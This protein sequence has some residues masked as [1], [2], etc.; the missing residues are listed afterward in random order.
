MKIIR[1]LLICIF[2]TNGM[3]LN[4]QNIL[5]GTGDEDSFIENTISIAEQSVTMESFQGLPP[6]VLKVHFWDVRPDQSPQLHPFLTEIECLNTVAELNKNYKIFNIFFKYDGLTDFL[7]DEH[8][9]IRDDDIYTDREDFEDFTALN[10]YYLEGAV[11]I[12]SVQAIEDASAYF[13]S[14]PDY[15]D[16]TTIVSAYNIIDHP[17]YS[18]IISHEVGH[19]FNLKH[20]FQCHQPPGDP[21]PTPIC[22][23]V[24]R[25][26]FLPDGVTPNP[27]YNANTKGDKIID[28]FA[29]PVVYQVTNCEYDDILVDQVGDFYSDFPPQTKNFMS[30]VN[31]GCQDEF[32]PGQG[33]HM[34]WHINTIVNDQN[35]TVIKTYPVSI[36]YEPYR[37]EYYNFGPSTIHNPPLFQYG[38]E[39]V[40]YDTTQAVTYNQ[41]SDYSD[42]SFWFGSIVESYDIDYNI[43]IVHKNHTAFKILEID[44]NYPRMCYN[45]F[46]KAPNGGTLIT[47]LDGIPNANVNITSQDSLQINNTNYIQNLNPGLYNVLKNYNDG[48]TEEQM[49]LKENN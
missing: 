47:F 2:I 38:F 20:T 29:S 1:L 5:C 22:E 28:T 27:D 39:Y 9:I 37:G 16:F 32:T 24:T 21:P 48:T 41:P 11:N 45:N 6:L 23:N 19:N 14:G 36:L 7:S 31:P 10:N 13:R 15:L 30:V 25:D 46:N 35:L 42:T 18:F 43:P 3:I 44:T 49:I 17:L 4:A 12:Y 26:P 33:V 40:F 8:Y 34:R